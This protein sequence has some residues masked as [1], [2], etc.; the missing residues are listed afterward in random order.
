MF[1][2][3]I[4]GD[5]DAE[6]NVHFDGTYAPTVSYLL[7]QGKL[8]T[9]ANTSL[10]VNFTCEEG[11]SY[12]SNPIKVTGDCYGLRSN[13]PILPNGHT[14]F[15]STFYTDLKLPFAWLDVSSGTF[16]T[17]TF[18]TEKASFISPI[19]QS[20]TSCDLTFANCTIYNANNFL[21]GA[22]GNAGW[23]DGVVLT[24]KN[25]GIA[26]TNKLCASPGNPTINLIDC[27]PIQSD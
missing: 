1:F 24:F 27:W 10:G 11:P 16:D 18:N 23:E 13:V 14:I 26:D 20:V 21:F 12:A 25:C 3:D 6:L 4:I 19:S 5:W 17:C 8:E 15:D 9:A 2:G 22:T 7:S